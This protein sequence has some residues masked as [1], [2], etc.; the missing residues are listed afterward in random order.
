MIA[1]VTLENK[2][3]DRVQHLLADNVRQSDHPVIARLLIGQHG[4]GRCD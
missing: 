2:Y 1:L 4:E 3:F